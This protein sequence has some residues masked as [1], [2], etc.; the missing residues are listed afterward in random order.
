MTESSAIFAQPDFRA[1]FESAPGSYLVLTPALFIVAVSDAYLRA[2]MT[3]REEILGRHLFDV[4]PDNPDDPSATGVSNLRASLNRVLQNRSSDALAVQKYDIRRP[5]SEGGGFEERYWSPVN[6]PVLDKNGNVAYILHRV[7]DVTEFVRLKQVG[8]EQHRVTEELRTRAAEMETEI[9]RRAQQIQ[10]ANSRLRAELAARGKAEEALRKAADELR[11]LYNNAPCGYHSLD[12]DGFFVAM[13]ETELTWLGYTREEVVGK[14]T[15]P[16]LLTAESST[17]FTENFPAFKDQGW[18][19][20][21]EF[22]MIRKDGTTFSVLLNATAIKDANGNYVASRTT[23]FDLTERK[24]AE[25]QFRAL[26]ESAPDAHVVVDRAGSIVRVNNQTE[27]LFGYARRELVG[28]SIELLLPERFRAGHASHRAGFFAHPQTRAMGTG[29][30]LYARRKDGSEFATEI[31]LNPLETDDGRLV[32][33]AIR[34]VAGRKKAEEAQRK[35]AAIVEFSDDAIMSKDLDGIIRSWNKGAERLFGYSAQEAIGCPVTML[36]SPEDQKEE[37]KILDRI[38]RG[39]NNKHYETIRI[40][41][42][43]TR[44]DVS[45]AVSP[46]KD[47]AGN[48]VSISKTARD[49]TERK[50]M[51]KALR[52]SEEK[53]RTLF[54]SIDVGV[55]TIEVLFDGNDKPVDYRFLEVNPSFEKQTGIQNAQGRRMR[56]I[57]P[58]HEEHWFEIY[59][60]IALTGEPARFESQAAQL[61]RWYD[62]YAFRVGEPQERQVAIHFK[63]ITERKRVEDALR[64]AHN[65]LEQRVEERTAE[66]LKKNRD[67][68]T[69]LYV[70][71]HDLREPLRS[72]ENFSRMVHNRYA[73]RLDDKG[74]DFLLR[75]VRGAQRLDKLMEDILALSR[76]QRM[77]LPA[78]E[79]ESGGLVQEVLRRLES[80]IK[81]TGATVK[82]TKN[83]PQLRA[84]STWATQGIYNLIA[85]ALKFRRDSEAPDIEIAPYPPSGED[86]VEVG[87]VV[88][89]RGPG[90]APEHAERIFQLFQ[91]AVGR[92]VEGTGAGLAIVRQ[93]AERHGGRAWVQPR[94][95]GGS[96]FIL[97]F[98]TA[99]ASERK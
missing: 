20:D 7:E 53:Y 36:I 29:R 73:E 47:A 32:I 18:V 45:L 69:L 11:D 35:L 79:V 40:K 15:F 60:K 49:I 98:G 61:H 48:V 54:D 4:F 12:K 14:L 67:L 91:R 92:E 68:E 1:L 19:R 94:D 82:V 71:S 87:I 80:T 8:S 90:V 81:E 59:G 43:G 57:A 86:G 62:V 85:N 28:Q 72:I 24:R 2:T 42:D 46:I 31:S 37:S 95:G 50:R 17:R 58:L 83:L 76:A 97:T 55:C 99:H 13:N 64:R 33:A 77:E 9:F 5:E 84:N 74:K 6:S 78:E 88:R 16:H 56:E 52:K 70:T 3:R 38:R 51:E 10:E 27:K 65:D 66:I 93:V 22:E 75:V 41:K 30:E 96:E 34:D 44:L 39:E 25:E 21:L 63:D 26:L 23:V 89:D